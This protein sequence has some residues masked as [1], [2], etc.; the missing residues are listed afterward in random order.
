VSFGAVDAALQLDRTFPVWHPFFYW[1]LLLLVPIS[2][3][4]IF[5]ADRIGNG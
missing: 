2:A 3:L 4:A 1:F 5:A